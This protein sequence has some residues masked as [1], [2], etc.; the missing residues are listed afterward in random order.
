MSDWITDRPPDGRDKVLITHYITNTE[1]R[2]VS[3]YVD[4]MEDGRI[5]FFDTGYGDM[6]YGDWRG[7]VIAWKPLPQPY[8]EQIVGQVCKMIKNDYISREDAIK[9]VEE[10]I[11]PDDGK[12]R[13]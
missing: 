12:G 9:K 5:M 11:L 7:D 10:H 2:V 4:Y 1:T 3:A 8:K 13:Q 6:W